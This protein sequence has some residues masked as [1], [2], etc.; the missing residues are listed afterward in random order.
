MP[1]G[2]LSQSFRNDPL[3]MN[4]PLRTLGPPCPHGGLQSNAQHASTIEGKF[5]YFKVDLGSSV[6]IWTM[7]NVFTTCHIEDRMCIALVHLTELHGTAD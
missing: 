5:F 4:V 1:C 7:L 6:V 3:H 2:I